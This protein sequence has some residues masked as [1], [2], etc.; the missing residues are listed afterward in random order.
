MGLS[1][2]KDVVNIFHRS[3]TMHERNKQ[4]D[5]GTVT[6]IAI[7]KIVGCLTMEVHMDMFLEADTITTVIQAKTTSER[8][9]LH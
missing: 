2:K 4:T 6:S 8:Q 5:H 7:D 1:Y 9:R 3:S